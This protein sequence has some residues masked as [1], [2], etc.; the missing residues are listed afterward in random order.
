MTTTL[1]E[2]HGAR[3]AEIEG[4]EKAVREAVKKWLPAGKSAVA[5]KSVMTHTEAKVRVATAEFNRL[6]GEIEVRDVQT[7]ADLRRLYNAG[8]LDREHVGEGAIFSEVLA[9]AKAVTDAKSAHDK[10]RA[11]SSKA[12]GKSGALWADAI[13]AGDVLANTTSF[14]V[15]QQ[16]AR[17]YGG[18]GTVPPY[19]DIAAVEGR[20]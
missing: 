17:N 1:T 10:A 4:A 3:L 2:K 11:E 13:R 8:D 12:H 18:L 5:A 6:I 16:F 14:E 7:A 15:Y 9:A 19:G 20:L